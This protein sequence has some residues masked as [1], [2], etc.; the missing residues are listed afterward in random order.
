MLTRTI[1]GRIDAEWDKMEGKAGKMRI[2][3]E[4]VQEIAN[5]VKEN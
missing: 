1:P 5:K 4:T 2:D 3:E